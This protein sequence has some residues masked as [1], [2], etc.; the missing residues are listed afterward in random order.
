MKKFGD[1]KKG[2]N[3]FLVKLGPK[4]WIIRPLKIL[5]VKPGI[6]DIKLTLDDVEWSGYY[7]K[8]LVSSKNTYIWSDREKALEFALENTKKEQDYLSNKIDKLISRYDEIEKF[9]EK[10]EGC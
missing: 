3:V 7:P 6:V 8:G 5:E 10:Y 9:I 1:L 4:E 2:D